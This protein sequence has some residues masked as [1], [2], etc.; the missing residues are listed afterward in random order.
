MSTGDQP[1]SSADLYKARREFILQNA[2]HKNI[3]QLSQ[4]FFEAFNLSTKNTALDALHASLKHYR[5]SQLTKLLKSG[6]ALFHAGKEPEKMSVQNIVYK[7]RNKLHITGAF[8]GSK[9]FKLGTDLLAPEEDRIAAWTFAAA[10][11]ERNPFLASR[12]SATLTS[13]SS[14]N[15]PSSIYTAPQQDEAHMFSVAEGVPSRVIGERDKRAN[16]LLALISANR[17]SRPFTFPPPSSS[18][19]E[20]AK[21][22]A[23][24]HSPTESETGMCDIVF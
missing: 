22:P 19:E 24:E 6:D 4:E 20:A 14:T 11:S 17:P 1:T 12:L 7:E 18:V 2:E 9:F 15:P 10:K 16:P 13:S 3:K 23:A 8:K 21:N 5:N